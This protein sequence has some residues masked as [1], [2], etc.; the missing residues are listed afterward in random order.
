MMDNLYR[1]GE[2]TATRNVTFAIRSERAGNQDLIEQVRQAAW[3]VNGNISL[4]AVRTMREIY[5]QSM[6]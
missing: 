2:A 5:G 6:A 1:A 3:S 4:T